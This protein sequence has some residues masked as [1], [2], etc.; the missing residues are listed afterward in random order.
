MSIASITSLIPTKYPS[1][2]KHKLG[3]TAV[4]KCFVLAKWGATSSLVYLGIKGKDYIPSPTALYTTMG[5]VGI[6]AMMLTRLQVITSQKVAYYSEIE[7]NRIFL[8]KGIYPQTTS[9]IAIKWHTV[10]LRIKYL[11]N[12]IVEK[13]NKRPYLHFTELAPT[14]NRAKKEDLERYSQPLID[15][16][17][18]RNARDLGFGI[19]PRMT[20]D[21]YGI[22]I[23][24]GSC[25]LF[26]KLYIENRNITKVS[27][28][29]RDGAPFEATVFQSE[30]TKLKKAILLPGA[31]SL[32]N[33]SHFQGSFNLKRT[34]VVF[35]SLGLNH[36][37][38]WTATNCKWIVNR[39]L[40][41]EVVMFFIS[42]PIFSS[43]FL[44][45]K[46]HVVLFI[47][48]KEDS[49]LFDPNYSTVSN[50]TK[51]GIKS[52]KALIESLFESYQLT[53]AKLLKNAVSINQID[54]STN[55]KKLGLERLTT[56]TTSGQS[57][58]YPI[59][60]SPV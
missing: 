46:Y 29:F 34:L 33:K 40:A 6:T 1:F 55:S 38:E 12:V 23:C 44:S 52:S 59:E 53:D 47:R 9:Q 21:P 11:H 19:S 7:E 15:S 50:T 48:E 35:Q 45:S 24:F 16:R 20:L 18:A 39:L 58:F 54:L 31:L 43:K 2:N 57:S 13:I 37:Q 22:G 36:I 60:L 41:E 51:N 42:F 8:E 10:K 49:Y 26:S 4:N 32:F 28:L 14:A 17:F 56:K 25:T 5:A 27:E 3:W 30:Y